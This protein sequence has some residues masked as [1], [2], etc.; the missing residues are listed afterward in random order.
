M[1][2]LVA[3]LLALSLVVPAGALVA[4]RRALAAAAA[5]AL[6]AIALVTGAATSGATARTAGLLAGIV[7]GPLV[8]LTYPRLRARHPV[9]VLA[10][11]AVG[12]A[13]PV[14]ALWPAQVDAMVLAVLLVLVGHVGWS[15]SRARGTDRRALTWLALGAA[16]AT[17]AALVVAFAVSGADAEPTPW[18]LL[19]FAVVGPA[20]AVGV[21]R[22]EVADTR[23]LVVDVVAHVASMLSVLAVF[24]GIGAPLLEASPDWQALSVLALL[25]AALAAAYAPVQGV[26]RGTVAELAGVRRDPLAAVGLVTRSLGEEPTEALEAVRLALGVPWAAVLAVPTLT[27]GARPAVTVRVPLGDDLP[28]LEV[29]LRDGDTRLGRADERLLALAAPLLGQSVRLHSL[30]EEVRRSRELTVLAL[31]DERVRLRRDLHDGLGP[32]L[33]G[34]AFTTDAASNLLRVDPDAAGALL[35]DVRR[36]AE[37]GLEDVRRLVYGMRPP[38]LDELGLVGAVRQATADLPLEVRVHGT[39]PDD[40]PA[41]VEVAAYRIAVEGACNAARHAS[42]TRVAVGVDCADD[43]LRV[44]VVD[45]GTTGSRWVPGVGLTSMQERAAEVG[46]SLSAGP[47]E[48]GGRVRAELPVSRRTR[49]WSSAG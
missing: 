41:A 2:L 15:L 18:S 34:L 35:A 26:L 32:L 43:V 47:A 23:V 13:G 4:R 5:M 36:Q 45:D 27:T 48:D 21:S 25:A 33:S 37:T 19:P 22:P 10:L 39:V 29:G 7:L 16:S 8:V 46:G 14:A 28:E 1:T 30:A 49:S 17:L 24:V 6:T 11:V 20:L 40:L 12:G 44:E 42:A 9:D 38:A 3:G 31:G